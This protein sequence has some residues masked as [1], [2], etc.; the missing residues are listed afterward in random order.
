MVQ[1]QKGCI[2]FFGKYNIILQKRKILGPL[3][4]A[5]SFRK[6]KLMVKI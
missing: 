6:L 4:Q 3:N 1:N 5:S 2:I